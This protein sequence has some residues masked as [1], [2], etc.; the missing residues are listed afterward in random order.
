MMIP[1]SKHCFY[2]ID[3]IGISSLKK[4]WKS[5]LHFTSVTF[6]LTEITKDFLYCVTD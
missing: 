4:M 6:F 3:D 2:D 1:R 5:E